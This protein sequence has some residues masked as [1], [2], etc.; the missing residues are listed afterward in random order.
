MTTSTVNP[1]DGAAPELDDCGPN[2]CTL[3]DVGSFHE[4]SWSADWK[5]YHRAVSK[6]PSKNPTVLSR[7]EPNAPFASPHVSSDAAAVPRTN[8]TPN[9]HLQKAE[10]LARGI[11]IWS[12]LGKGGQATV[13]KASCSDTTPVAV[14]VIRK[15]VEPKTGKVCPRQEANVV[16]ETRILS[17]LSGNPGVVKFNAFY[18]DSTD[19]FIV[20][21][22]LPGTD[23]FESLVGRRCS[24]LEALKCMRGL[25][26]ALAHLHAQGI[27]HRDIKLENIVWLRRGSEHV[28]LIDFGY[29]QC[30]A[31]W[32]SKDA[33]SFPG[34]AQYKSPE[35]LERK[36]GYD[37]FAADMWACGI[38]LHIMLFGECPNESEMALAKVDAAA[39]NVTVQRSRRPGRWRHVS[40][41][42]RRLNKWLLSENPS[43][44]PTA[45]QALSQLDTILTDRH[46]KNTSTFS[47]MLSAATRA[48]I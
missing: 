11:L 15:R 48:D 5:V 20:T 8:R 7:A 21:E 34:T 38:V 27:A 47:R 12:E 37:L 13:Y 33:S 42:T 24:E 6:T 25:L 1:T 43:A 4:F 29:A 10:L 39:T 36:P 14:K 44:R 22:L 2:S 31:I 9:F 19:W 18:E 17:S 26:K 40:C 35:L 16:G 32:D 23:L 30:A 3:N 41:A 46:R 28:K 45:Q